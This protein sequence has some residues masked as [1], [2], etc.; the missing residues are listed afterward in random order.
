MILTFAVAQ[1]AVLLICRK[2]GY[3]LAWGRKPDA[4]QHEDDVNRTASDGMEPRRPE[5][6][7]DVSSPFLDG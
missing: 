2:L 3:R 6:V 1:M 5:T 4:R 7:S